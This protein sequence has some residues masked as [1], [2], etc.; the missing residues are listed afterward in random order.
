MRTLRL[1]FA[2]PLFLCI[3][4][5]AVAVGMAWARIQDT[6]ST[7]LESGEILLRTMMGQLQEGF[8][9][10]MIAENRQAAL[11]QLTSFALTPGIE[12]LLLVD[13]D[14]K[15]VMADRY[16]WRGE[17]ASSVSSYDEKTV[18]G[19]S[20]NQV[21]HVATDPRSMRIYGYFPITIG[22][23]AGEILPSR[24]AVLYVDYS[25][26]APFLAARNKAYRDAGIF[27]AI[28]LLLATA[29][30]GTLHLLVTRRV[31]R[32]T[33]PLPICHAT[34]WTPGPDTGRR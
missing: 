17:R 28:F 25:L 12:A 5:G 8:S 23:Q 7:V 10:F 11:Q 29:L 13:E 9:A 15:V 21:C 1:R 34:G 26:L 18:S 2:L 19:V 27:G 24:R 33:P 31:E 20:R 4:T 6:R 30:A 32:L 16:E 14:H 3:F 22:R